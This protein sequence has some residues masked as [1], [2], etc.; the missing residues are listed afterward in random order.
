M[1][2]NEWLK[3]YK[4]FFLFDFVEKKIESE[5]KNKNYSY[6]RIKHNLNNIVKQN[7]GQI[8]LYSET[9]LSDKIRNAKNLIYQN[10]P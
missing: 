2:N 7:L 6:N 8:R 3:E 5:Y 4:E 10:K 1:I 9:K